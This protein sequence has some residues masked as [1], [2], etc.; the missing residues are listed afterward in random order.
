MPCTKQYIRKPTIQERIAFQHSTCL[1]NYRE[2]W[3][4]SIGRL[5]NDD[6][7]NSYNAENS[8]TDIKEVMDLIEVSTAQSE[9]QSDST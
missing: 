9:A 5:K 1:I 8:C 4:I 6:H 3:S 2:V 7:E